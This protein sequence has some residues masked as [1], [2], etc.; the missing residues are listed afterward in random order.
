MK[1]SDLYFILIVLLILF[2]FIPIPWLKEQLQDPF[3]YNESYW[4]I[5]SFIKFALLATLG[6]VLGLRIK[7][8]GYKLSGFGVLPRALVWGVLGITIKMAMVVCAA[9]VPAFLAKSC[10]MP[11]ALSAMK[12]TDVLEAAGLGLGGVRILTAFCISVFMNMTF[13]PVMMTFHKITDTHIVDHGGTLAGCLRPINMGDIFTR[14]NWKVQWNFVFK[15]TIP[16]FWFPAHTITFLL[17]GEYRIVFAA[18]LGVALGLI[19]ALAS[20]KGKG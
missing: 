11:D 4:V 17:P 20:H 3:L 19:L 9:G 18:I 16:F 2:P 5:T 7:S 1:R 15:K 14:I 12:A 6:E 10:A 8:G 13:A